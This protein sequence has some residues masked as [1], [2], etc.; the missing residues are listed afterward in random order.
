MSD[1]DA[2]EA[3]WVWPKRGGHRRSAV[4]TGGTLRARPRPEQAPP[5]LQRAAARQAAAGSAGLPGAATVTGRR[6]RKSALPGWQRGLTHGGADLLSGSANPA[7]IRHF[8][9]FPVMPQS[10]APHL[11]I[12]ATSLMARSAQSGCSAVTSVKGNR[13]RR[14]MAGEDARGGRAYKR[15]DGA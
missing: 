1:T 10:G 15:A 7:V 3:L 5:G 2:A 11:L 12:G 6:R 9:S 14:E 13:R 4:E 8:D